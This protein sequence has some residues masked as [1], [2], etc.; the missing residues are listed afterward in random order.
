M[1]LLADRQQN[2][3]RRCILKTFCRCESGLSVSYPGGFRVCTT[4]A[5]GA[6]WPLTRATQVRILSD[7]TQSPPNRWAFVLLTVSR[8]RTVFDVHLGGYSPPPKFC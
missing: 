8:R 4:N 5:R 3:T 1:A 7:R 2:L 6:S